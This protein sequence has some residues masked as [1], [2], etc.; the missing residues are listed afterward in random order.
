MSSPVS[1]FSF[2][3]NWESFAQHALNAQRVA[4]ARRDFAELTSGIALRNKTF[5]DVGFGQGLALY[6]AAEAGAHAEG[7]DLDPHC[8]RA[9]TLTARFFPSI[10]M[11][12]FQIASIL[13][14]Q[15]V[16]SQEPFDIVHSWGVLHHTG[17]MKRAMGNAMRLVKPR[18]YFI[19]AIYNRHWTSPL[20]HALKRAYNALP[21]IGQNFL[22]AC[23]Y[24]PMWARVRMLY[25]SDPSRGMEFEHDL[26]D[27]LGGYPYEYASAN[28]IIA[29]LS[30]ESFRCMRLIPANGWTGCNQFVFERME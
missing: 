30:K 17:N 22:F 3:R 1:A 19:I 11:P 15:F 25:K 26:R 12:R 10:A 13:E 23:T 16:S 7:I 6:L 21:P 20:W 4:Q 2:G 28:E 27:W 14:Q 18:G 9:L 24:V 5:L 29:A 8:E